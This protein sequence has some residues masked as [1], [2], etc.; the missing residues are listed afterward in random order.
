MS[1]GSRVEVLDGIRGIAILLVL[2]LHLYLPPEGGPWSVEF[3][4]KILGAMWTGV[5][6]FFVLSG[7][8]I[9]GLLLK[10]K[11]SDGYFRGFY[12]R[13]SL[14]IFPAYYFVLFLALAVL[15]TIDADV[16]STG[17]QEHAWTFIFY[18]QNWWTTVEGQRFAWLGV[19]HL[20][21]LAVEEQFYLLW[22]LLVWKLDR[23]ELMRMCVLLIAAC[24]VVKAAWVA[25]HVPHIVLQTSTLSSLDGLAA[26]ALIA[27]LAPQACMKILAPARVLGAVCALLMAV[28]VAL[29]PAPQRMAAYA[30]CSSLA[31]GIFAVLFLHVRGAGLSSGARRFLEQP[32]LLWL[33]R[34]SYGIY[35]L[36]FVIQFPLSGALLRSVPGLHE[37]PANLAQ[38]VVGTATLAV[39]LPAAV[40]MFHLLEQPFL[41]L[42]DKGAATQDVPPQ[43][44]KT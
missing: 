24:Q 20:W 22:P 6:L 44:S 18:L 36:H 23:V 34:Y 21:S 2:L 11:G 13:R 5:T 19:A 32:M 31:V 12:A 33:G 42:R 10:A 25:S 17:I 35:L 8:L 9:T 4:R 14:R 3:A 7:Y 43:T 29:Y 1:K 40:A 41:R 38:I 37:L 26:G 39:T 15:P 27:T 28:L 16:R 30:A